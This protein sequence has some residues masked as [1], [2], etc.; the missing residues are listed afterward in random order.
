M[1]KKT[2]KLAAITAAMSLLTLNSIPSIAQSTLT[3]DEKKS[4]A[5][6]AFIYAFPMIIAY[7][8]MYEYSVDKN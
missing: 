8:I 2:F 7:G 4:I 3:Q 5:E 6:E 1:P